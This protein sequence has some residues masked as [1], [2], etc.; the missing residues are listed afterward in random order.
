[1]SPGTGTPSAVT[2]PSSV[3]QKS[4]SPATEQ[5]DKDL[6]AML[7]D[8]KDESHPK[9]VAGQV[10]LSQDAIRHRMRRVMHP[11]GPNPKR[12]LPDEIVKQ[13]DKGGKARKNLESIFQSCG[14]NPDWC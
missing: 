2:T 9:P 14:Y 7:L 13:Y 12:R 3:S 10:R 11:R 5:G 4:S 1:M 6:S 8:V